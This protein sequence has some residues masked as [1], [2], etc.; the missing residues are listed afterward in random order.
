[1]RAHSCCREL[2][3]VV[4]EL[5]ARV[6]RAEHLAPDFLRRLHL[7]RDLVRPFVRDVAVGALRA[8][9]RPVRVV[10]RAAELDEHVVA[11][12]VA[13]GAERLGVGELERGVERAPEHYAG[14]EPADDE[15]AEAV[16]D[17]RAADRPP[18]SASRARS[19]TAC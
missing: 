8:H 19:A 16:V 10:D 7:A 3:P 11:H 17:A 12:L 4:D 2:E 15:E 9:A 14:D 6:D 1:M 13:A 5:L 18:S